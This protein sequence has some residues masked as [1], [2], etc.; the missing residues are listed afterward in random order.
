MFS[1]AV[2]D[3]PSHYKIETEGRFGSGFRFFIFNN[4]DCTVQH[5]KLLFERGFAV[6]DWTD[7]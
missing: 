1:L 4:G 2:H 3:Y 7:A 5:S 6:G